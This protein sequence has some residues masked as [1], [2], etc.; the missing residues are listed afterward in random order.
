MGVFAPAVKERLPLRDMPVA[1]FAGV[2]LSAG[3]VLE[4]GL[5]LSLLQEMIKNKTK[6]QWGILLSMAWLIWLND[7]GSKKAITGQKPVIIA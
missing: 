6:R 4:G 7:L 3:P 5:V 1:V 2:G